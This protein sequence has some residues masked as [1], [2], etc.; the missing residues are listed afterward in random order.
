MKG[1]GQLFCPVWRNREIHTL[2]HVSLG[3]L[4]A[5]ELVA[6]VTHRD[7][8]PCLTDRNYR[9]SLLHE[10]RRNE[11]LEHAADQMRQMRH[12]EVYFGDSMLDTRL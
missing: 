2:M 11:S 8:T 12:D 3:F 10:K 4:P 1:G 6:A 5:Y 9:A 7:V